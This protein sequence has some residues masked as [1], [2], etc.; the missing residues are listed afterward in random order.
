MDNKIKNTILYLLTNENYAKLADLNHHNTKRLT[1][2][3]NVTVASINFAK[4]LH[5]K[6]DENALIRG[7]LLH[8][9]FLYD[10]YACPKHKIHAFYHAKVAVEN[11]EKY[12]GINRIETDMIL[13]HMFPLCLGIPKYKETWIITLTDKYCAIAEK[14]AHKDE[15]NQIKRHIRKV[16]R[17]GINERRKVQEAFI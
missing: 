4:A 10:K 6:V 9:F 1:H 2:I 12:F 14:F 5:I 17:N 13:K 8:D 3:I 15:T 11:A 7:C 16:I